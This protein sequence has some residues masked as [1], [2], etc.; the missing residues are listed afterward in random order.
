MD[1]R[2]SEIWQAVCEGIKKNCSE[3]N[4]KLW[5]SPLVLT[6]MTDCFVFFTYPSTAKRNIFFIYHLKVLKENLDEVLG[7]PT[8]V[9]ILSLEELNQDLKEEQTQFCFDLCKNRK[10]SVDELNNADASF[11]TDLLSENNLLE[12]D[13]L[14]EPDYYD[15][16]NSREQIFDSK[17]PPKK[18]QM[19]YTFENFVVG[20]SNKFAHAAC[21]AAADKP[22]GSYNPL[23]IY[24]P[25][26]LGKTHLLYAISNQ[27]LKNNPKAI[28]IYVKSEEFL[29]QL[30]DSVSKHN[31]AAFRQKYRNCDV[32]L[33]DDVQFIAGKTSV[34]EE[35]FHT[36]NALFENKKQIILTSDRPPRELSSLE[37]RIRTRFEWGLMADIQPPD[38]ELRMAILKRKAEDL[39]IQV[40]NE[41]L[42]FLA[43]NIKSNIRQIEGA[44]KK[45][46][47]YSKLN[48]RSISI[49][50]AK[51]VV[52]DILNIEDLAITKDKIINEV[53]A[54]YNVNGEEIRGKKR[55][56]NIV[57]ARFVAIYLLRTL[58][59]M[60]SPEIGKEFQ[61]DH[62]TVLNAETKI[63]DRLKNDPQ[64]E[65][66]INL[67]IK[68]IKS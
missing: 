63:S 48:G 13:E 44:I 50:L 5:Y 15:S 38:L 31:T 14:V 26:G 2:F 52:G 32:L 8:D 51:S 55:T 36:F 21:I 45:L 3:A 35:F 43:E 33:V 68:K 19:E 39:G 34:Q 18:Y 28:I 53:S 9:V 67:L 6:E 1:S 23:F 41:V 22:G 27:I 40:S 59:E 17:N 24:G 66:E 10:V 47:A 30:I 37:E 58:T 54:F 65:Y 61:R 60:S 7:F 56:S 25:S 11:I 16:L 20:N 62:T 12:P 57:N 42:T 49:D 29:N 64:L 46:D 4:F